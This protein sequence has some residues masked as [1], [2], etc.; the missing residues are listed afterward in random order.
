MVERYLACACLKHGFATGFF[1]LPP[2]LRCH[3]HFA[4]AYWEGRKG[5]A[6]Y[7]VGCQDA[8]PRHAECQRNDSRSSFKIRS[9]WPRSIHR[10]SK[11]C[12]IRPV[13]NRYGGTAPRGNTRLRSRWRWR[14]PRLCR[15]A[16]SLCLPHPWLNCQNMPSPSVNRAILVT[17]PPAPRGVG[18]LRQPRMCRMICQQEIRHVYN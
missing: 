17:E 11:C 13:R 8:P 6:F 18:E 4:V 7:G 5:N 14:I 10:S 16:P 3:G 2:S 12:S 9:S 15:R 1:T